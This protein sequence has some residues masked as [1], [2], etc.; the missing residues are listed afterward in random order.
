MLKYTVI[1]V[2][3]TYS[4][5]VGSNSAATYRIS[6]NTAEQPSDVN[7][8]RNLQPLNSFKRILTASVVGDVCAHSK[9][10]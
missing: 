8:K 7:E 1:G 2:H 10:N 9:T 5:M 6:G 3:F 4:S